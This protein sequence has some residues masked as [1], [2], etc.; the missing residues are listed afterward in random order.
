MSVHL[1]H[2]RWQALQFDE[3]KKQLQIGD[4][5]L[6][7]DF[8]TNYSHHRQDEIHGAFWCRRQTTLHPIIIYYPCQEKRVSTPCS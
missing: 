1:F 8:A 2:F 7:M 5:L 3:A 4:I 6:I